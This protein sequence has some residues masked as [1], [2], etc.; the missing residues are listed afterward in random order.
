M[1]KKKKL[2]YNE[3]ANYVV[4]FESKVNDAVNVIGKTMTDYIEF[5]KDK[6]KFITHLKE[7]YEKK[8]DDKEKKE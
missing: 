1:S 2:T 6:D 8:E 5:K 4:N 7:K 3:L